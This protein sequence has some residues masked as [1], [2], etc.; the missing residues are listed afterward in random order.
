MFACVHAHVCTGLCLNHGLVKI[1]KMG[2][3]FW[4][5]D[6]FCFVL[7]FTWR[8]LI[9]SHLLSGS[10]D[11]DCLMAVLKALGLGVIQGL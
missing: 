3:C 8:H 1:K 9:H 11:I 6:V 2:F 10:E 5:V 7:A 4:Q